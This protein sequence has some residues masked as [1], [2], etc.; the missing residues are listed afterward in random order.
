MLDIIIFLA[1]IGL[2]LGIGRYWSKRVH[3]TE[4]FHL[5][6]RQLGRLPA[7]LSLAA[8]EFSGSGLIGGAGLVYAIGLSGIF[9][10]YAAIPAYILLGFLVAPRLRRLQLTTIPE[11]I[12]MKFGVS[13]QRL[14]A[15]LEIVEAVA[16]VAVQILVSALLLAALFGLSV[17]QASLLVTAA[18]AIYTMMGGL[19]AVVWTDAL[20][21]VILM[22]GIIVAVILAMNAVGGI[23]G[24]H[25]RLPQEHF[26]FTQLGL[27]TPL[28]WG[29]LALYSYGVD[30]AYMQRALAAKDAE[31][32]RFAYIFTGCNYVIFG[33]CVAI[34]GLAAA[35]LLPGLADENQALP[36]LVAQVLPEG[37]RALIM[38]AIIAA[39][40]S[41]SSSFLAAASSLAVQ[42]LYEP[43][44]GEGASEERQIFHSRV[45]TAVFAATALG[46]SLVFPG[47]VSLVVF[48]TLVAPAAIF[49]PFIMSIFWDKT[50]AHAGFWAILASAVA[51]CSSQ[52]FWYDQVA[53]WLGAIHP[54]FIAPLAA[55]AV[56]IPAAVF[57]RTQVSKSR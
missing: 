50:P 39:T 47:V 41:T 21:Y 28:A 55:L 57:N 40:M 37:V 34:L 9:W 25:S 35:A 1:Y 42:D 17:P 22:V 2:V 24:L 33:G 36:E 7:S 48:A 27:W 20:Q 45:I 3:S 12:G 31:T 44:F 43:I 32:A 53:G 49:I 23:D 14:T 38:T 19:W 11:Y 13:T 30:Q 8:T 29:A 4:D 16:F 15:V 54:L 46:I 52:I 5:C 26:S 51:G 56:M 10:N 6:G 18:F